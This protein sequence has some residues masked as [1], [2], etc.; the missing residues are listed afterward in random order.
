MK[1]IFLDHDGVICLQSECGGRFDNS[2]GLDSIFDKF[3]T[4]AIK[5]LNEILA[6]TDAEIVV[7]S[8]WRFHVDL[9]TM[10]ELYKVRGIIKS[11]IAYTGSLIIGKSVSD[12]ELN[13]QAEIKDWLLKHPEVTHWVAIDDMN[14]SDEFINQ[15]YGQNGLTNFVQ[16]PRSREGIKQSGIKQKVLKFL[17]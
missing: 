4:G 5:V 15:R 8:D 12:L 7:S 1:V 6:E 11:P 9:A 17:I 10:Q 16:T 13:R 3:N 2:E 14:M